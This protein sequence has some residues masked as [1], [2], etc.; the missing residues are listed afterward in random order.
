MNAGTGLKG[1]RV[2]AIVQGM[3][4]NGTVHFGCLTRIETQ[5]V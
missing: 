2:C 1:V 5:I 3:L 4:E